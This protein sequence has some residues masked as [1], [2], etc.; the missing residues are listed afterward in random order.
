MSEPRYPFVHVDVTP[1][2]VDETSGLLFELG[3]EGVEERDE[4]TLAKSAAGNRKGN[5]RRG[6]FDARGSRGGHRRARMTL[7]LATKR[8]SAMLGGTRGRSTTALHH[9]AAKEGRAVVV[10]PPWEAYEAK[11]GESVLELEPGRAFGTGL[12]ETTRLVAQ[13]IAD[14]VDELRNSSSSTS[15]AEAAFSLSSH[16]RSARRAPS[17][18]TSIPKA[19]DVTRENAA[20]NAMSD[21]VDASTTSIEDAEARVARRSREHRG[22]H[23]HPDG[24]GARAA[25]RRPAASCSCRA[26]SSRSRM[27]CAPHTRTS[28]FLPRPRSASGR[29][30]HSASAAERRRGYPMTVRAPIAGLAQGERVLSAEASR[31]L[32]RVRRLARRSSLRRVRSRGPHGGRC[33]AHRGIGRGRAR[34]HRS[35]E[36]RANRRRVRARPRLR[37]RQR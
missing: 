37:A 8:S 1:E 12:H 2:M 31:Y 9:R 15:V 18:S 16:S 19:I 34:S 24:H 23:P 21:R 10:R 13:A 17:R 33:H 26:S 6:V 28:S 20:R 4:G 27:T 30:S 11:P 7:A 14:H 35:A 3:A 25:R 5:A 32:C 22:A 29:C 36:T